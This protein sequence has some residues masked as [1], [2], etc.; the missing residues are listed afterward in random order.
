[1]TINDGKLAHLVRQ[2][3]I[4]LGESTTREDQIAITLIQLHILPVCCSSLSFSSYSRHIPKLDFGIAWMIVISRNRG[5]LCVTDLGYF[6]SKRSKGTI[7]LQ[8][9]MENRVFHDQSFLLSSR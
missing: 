3:T 6:L 1:M 2:F 5:G 9:F 7:L 8:L 4:V